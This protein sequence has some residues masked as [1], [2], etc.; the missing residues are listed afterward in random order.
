MVNGSSVWG[1]ASLGIQAFVLLLCITTSF[2]EDWR[3]Y[4]DFYHMDT[5]GLELR[6]RE[7]FDEDGSLKSEKVMNLV[8][9][10]PTERF[11]VRVSGSCLVADQQVIANV[12][13]QNV[14]QVRIK[15]D[16]SRSKTEQSLE[17]H[18]VELDMSGYEKSPNLKHSQHYNEYKIFDRGHKLPI[19]RVARENER[20]TITRISILIIRLEITP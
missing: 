3:L 19:C 18:E 12:S 14:G 9:S 16:A 15:I 11:A 13:G 8:L 5:T 4:Y 2:A 20:E 17:I 1:T 10:Q 7:Y 6:S